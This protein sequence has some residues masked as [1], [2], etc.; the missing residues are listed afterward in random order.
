[1]GDRINIIGAGLA[2]SEAAWQV[3]NRGVE[4][5][6]YEM[7]PY[8]NT[9]AHHTKFFAELVCSNSLRANNINNAA[10]LLKEE[11]RVLDSLIISMADL[12]NVPAGRALAVDRDRFSQAITE[13]L[14]KHPLLHFHNIEV[15]DIPE[16]ELVIVA[17]GPLTSDKFSNSI[18]KLTGEEHLFFFDAA[19]P[20]VTGESLDFSRLFKASR[21]DENG[22]GDYLN[23]S[24]NK[25]DYEKFWGV[26]ISAE[27]HQPHDFEE[28]KY[29]EGCLPIEVIA[30]RGIDT[31]R[32]G[33]LK[34]VGIID[35]QTGKQPYAVIQ[36][37]QDNAMATLFNLV[38]FQTRLKWAEQERVLRMI[39][40]L[41]RV[42]IVRY[43][44]MHRN[45]YLNSPHILETTYQLKKRK[46]IFFAGQITGVEGYI[47]SAASGLVAGINAVNYLQK[48]EPL[49][50]PETTAHG[51]L[52][53]YIS[54]SSKNL[55]QP[56]NINFGLFPPLELRIR[57][58]GKRREKIAERALNDLKLFFK[59]KDNLLKK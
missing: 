28:G 52:S 53:S 29:F 57:D 10:G 45:T 49:S 40:G 39:P 36:L 20:I 35:P 27:R 22:K 17:S 47:E 34:P 26:L 37:R 8:K 58:K 59:K 30:E 43:G 42:E 46:N 48:R 32:F 12:Y 25:Q 44:V 24:M 16:N 13:K 15:E 2:G 11:M 4:V 5:N 19:A 56:I 41:E 1:M 9:A 6:L 55:L 54:D 31:L 18:K 7:R 23:S 14:L 33:P 38:G 21:Y 3:L 50:F 51:A